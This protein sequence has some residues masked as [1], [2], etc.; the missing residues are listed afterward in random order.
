MWKTLNVQSISYEDIRRGADKLHELLDGRII[1]PDWLGLLIVG[2]GSAIIPPL[3]MW[4]I[5]RKMI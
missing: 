1:I 2:V 3:V 5:W 4:L